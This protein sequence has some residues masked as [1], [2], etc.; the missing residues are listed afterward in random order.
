M[1][2]MAYH[3]YADNSVDVSAHDDYEGQSYDE[4]EAQWED[5]DPDTTWEVEEQET[6][7]NE[8]SVTLSSK[9]SKR[10]FDEVELEEDEVDGK[11]PPGSPGT[12]PSY[13]NLIFLTLCRSRSQ[14]HTSRLISA[15]AHTPP[16]RC[17]TTPR[18]FFRHL[19]SAL[20]CIIIPHLDLAHFRQR[21]IP[22]LLP[23]ARSFLNIHH[24]EFDIVYFPICLC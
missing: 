11:S 14:T 19:S 22:F 10:S 13:F 7:S 9:A 21:I 3:P 15:I 6:A 20:H 8:S 24:P 12:L 4:E 18:F 17:A 16:A 2:Q 5:G 23:K 1:V